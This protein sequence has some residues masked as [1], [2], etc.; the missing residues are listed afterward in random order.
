MKFYASMIHTIF[1]HNCSIHTHKCTSLPYYIIYLFWLCTNEWTQVYTLALYCTVL[2]LCVEHVCL[3]C[4]QWQHVSQW[5]VHHLY[6][7][8]WENHSWR[9]SGHLPDSQG[10]K[11]TE[12]TQRSTPVWVLLEYVYSHSSFIIAFV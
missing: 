5:C 10:S 12:T 1:T 4:R 7:G 6:E 8:N 3:V 11:G 2:S 9:I